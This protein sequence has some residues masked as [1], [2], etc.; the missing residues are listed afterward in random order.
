[1]PYVDGIKKTSS[2][3][4]LKLKLNRNS[5]NMYVKFVPVPDVGER[6]APGISHRPE[7]EWD[8]SSSE[9]SA[10]SKNKV[11]GRNGFTKIAD[12]LVSRELATIKAS[13]GN[14]A[15]ALLTLLKAPK[16]HYVYIQ[17]NPV[18]VEKG[19]PLCIHQG[20]RISLYQSKYEYIC[21]I[22]QSQLQHNLRSSSNT[23]IT[24]AAQLLSSSQDSMTQQPPQQP[25]MMTALTMTSGTS[26]VAAAASLKIP[27]SS[28][29]SSVAPPVPLTASASLPKNNDNDNNNTA[30]DD[31]NDN[32]TMLKK[33]D[34]AEESMCSICMDIIV[35]ATSIVPCGHMFCKSCLVKIKKCPTCRTIKCSTTPSKS[36]DNMIW[37][38]VRS[39]YIF[40]QDDV[41][42]YLQRSRKTLTNEESQQILG[43]VV[44]SSSHKQPLQGKSSYLSS[45]PLN[46]RRRRTKTDRQYNSALENTTNSQPIV[47]ESSRNSNNNDNSFGAQVA[48]Y[49]NSARRTPSYFIHAV[50]PRSRQQQGGGGGSSHEDAICID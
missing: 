50:A 48:S 14:P 4:T 41:E 16:D 40:Q 46:K 10:Q 30:N 21:H 23:T 45:S 32:N 33:D 20:D 13:S 39:K 43:K 25:P 22:T 42:H 35:Q 47:V 8:F 19:L 11:L 37:H 18:T 27:A 49:R 38:L 17:G 12:Q 44:S 1:V 36:F 31:D 34:L 24:P 9:T 28:S 3:V 2:E 6:L 15:F 26:T 5:N 7:L 29:S